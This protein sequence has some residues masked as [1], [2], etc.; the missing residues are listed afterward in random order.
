MMD[1]RRNEVVRDF[2]HDAY[3]NSY[4]HNKVCFG[5]DERYVIAGGGI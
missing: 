3:M 2:M 4:D 1:L 5:P